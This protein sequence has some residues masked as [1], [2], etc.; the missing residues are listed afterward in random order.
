M[1]PKH[2]VYAGI[3]KDYEE[4]IDRQR[5]DIRKLQS[6]FNFYKKGAVP[7]S[8]VKEESP[9]AIVD[10]VI[11]ALPPNF[12]TMIVPFRKQIMEYAKE[13]P[14]MV[15]TAVAALQSNF[16]KKGGKEEIEQSIDAV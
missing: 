2:R 6:A 7:Q 4:V 5:H 13:N 10:A 8:V 11:S 16:L 1:Q 15:Q 14:E 9:E 12:K 3:V